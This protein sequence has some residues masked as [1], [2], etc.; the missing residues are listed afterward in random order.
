ME[1]PPVHGA[2]RAWRFVRES[3][4]RVHAASGGLKY[5]DLVRILKDHGFV[6]VRQT[7]SHRTF[8]GVVNGRC[9]VV[10]VAY[11]SEGDDILP[12]NLASMMRQSGL[13]KR[14]FR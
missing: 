9:M 1:G 8:D 7:G 6:Q 11:H 13:P 3:A 2:W 14:L 12:R 4:R 10:T 5:R